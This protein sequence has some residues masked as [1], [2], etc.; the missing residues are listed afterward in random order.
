MR[1]NK[2]S[3]S[4]LVW[5]GILSFFILGYILLPFVHTFLQALETDTGFGF[6]VFQEFFSNENHI[7]TVKNTFLLGAL[8]VL[9]CGTIGIMLAMYMTFL[10]G[11]WKKIIHILL[12]SPMMIP[13]VIIVISFIQLYGESGII[14]KA[15]QYLFHL[16]RVPFQ[17]QGLGAILFVITFTQY[18]YFYQHKQQ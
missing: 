16:E 12:L 14:T 4:R 9:S 5:Y 13:G 11:K 18:V 10:V 7:T 8:S 3:S 2:I 17:F 15:I 1:K 6:Q